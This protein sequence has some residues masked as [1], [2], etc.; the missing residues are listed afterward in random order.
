MDIFVEA[1]K[2]KVFVGALEWPGW[3][4]FGRDE[5]TALDAFLA[6]EPSPWAADVNWTLPP[7]EGGNS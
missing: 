7:G 5:F 6:K 1:G 3:C 4:R 2:Q